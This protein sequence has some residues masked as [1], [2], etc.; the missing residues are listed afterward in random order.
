MRL[1]N[2]KAALVAYDAEY[3]RLDAVLASAHNAEIREA[4]DAWMAG[5]DEALTKLRTA[6]WM[7]TKHTNSLDHCMV[8]TVSDMRSLV[9]TGRWAS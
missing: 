3:K 5:H 7:D 6:F 9:M 4:G 8:V 2:T 1:P